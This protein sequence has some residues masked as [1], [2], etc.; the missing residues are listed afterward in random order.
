MISTQK[1]RTTNISD[2][3]TNLRDHRTETIAKAKEQKQIELL[4][5]LSINLFKKR[6]RLKIRLDSKDF[7]QYFERMTPQEVLAR[8]YKVQ[9]AGKLV[10]NSFRRLLAKKRSEK[11]KSVNLV[12]LRSLR[13]VDTF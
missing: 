6:R 9:R 3:K 10:L 2:F 4:N 8:W 7:D 11:Q 13:F 1:I 12:Y 5:D